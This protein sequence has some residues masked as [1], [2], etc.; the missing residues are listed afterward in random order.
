M[1][2]RAEENSST[3]YNLKV[4]QQTEITIMLDHQPQT[5]PFVLPILSTS[6]VTKFHRQKCP[7]VKKVVHMLVVLRKTIKMF[8]IP[9]RGTKKLCG[10]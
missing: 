10:R 4:T 9:E 1:K 2:I 8:V 3:N 5:Y 7:G 6:V